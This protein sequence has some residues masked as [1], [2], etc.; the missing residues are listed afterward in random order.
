M[1]PDEFQAAALMLGFAAI[2]CASSPNS[3]GAPM[4]PFWMLT[5]VP[6]PTAV[7]ATA[8]AAWPVMNVDVA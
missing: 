7:P 2:P 3:P 1:T 4:T 8:I 6:S 5:F